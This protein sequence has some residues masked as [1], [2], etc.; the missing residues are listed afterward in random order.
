M[1][2]RRRFLSTVSAAIAGMMMLAA[3]GANENP[4]ST[5]ATD[6]AATRT[7]VDFH[8]DE[9]E[10]PEAP[11]RIVAL[12][13]PTVDGLL[14]LDIEPVGISAGRGQAGAAP[15][16]GEAAAAI[17]IVG[18]VGEPNVEAIGAAAPDLIVLDDSAVQK[19][20]AVLEQLKQIAPVFNAGNSANGWQEGLA[21]LAEAVNKNDEAQRVVDAYEDRV[22]EVKDK[23]GDEYADSTFSIVRWQGNG[24]SLILKELAPG[25]VLSDLGLKRPAAQDREGPGHSE[26]VSNENMRDIDA[27]YIFFG[28]LGGSS[29]GNRAAGGGADADASARALES[30]REVPG[31]AELSAV[32]ENRVIA[33]DGAAWTSAGGPLQAMRILDD[34]EAALHK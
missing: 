12:T 27:D 2:T 28:S 11:Q 3:C 32:R 30:A 10:V 14:A 17:D 6:G 7:V 9:V 21:L 22:A 31:F 20:P 26:P 25:R 24:P 33:V 13:E 19:D 4:A 34:I 29:V 8:G 5:T 15:Y 1:T 18:Q 23:L 16:L